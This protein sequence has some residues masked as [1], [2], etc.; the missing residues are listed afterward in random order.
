MILGGQVLSSALLSSALATMATHICFNHSNP[1]V[2]AQ[3]AMEWSS[4]VKV[5]P[6]PGSPTYSKGVSSIGMEIEGQGSLSKDYTMDAC[7]VS[8]NLPSYDKELPPIPDSSSENSDDLESTGLGFPH[9]AVGA[10]YTSGI[11]QPK[12]SVYSNAPSS[13][14]DKVPAPRCVEEV[15]LPSLNRRVSTPSESAEKN[16]EITDEPY[17]D[18]QPC[19]AKSVS[20]S[21]SLLG[22]QPS[23]YDVVPPPRPKDEADKRKYGHYD[24][25]PSPASESDEYIPCEILTSVSPKE[26]LP[27]VPAQTYNGFDRLPSDE[28]VGEN[29]IYDV[30]PGG[31]SDHTALVSNLHITD[32]NSNSS[33]AMQS[34]S[35]SSDEPFWEGTNSQRLQYDGYHSS[36][37]KP[38]GAHVEDPVIYDDPSLSHENQVDDLYDTPPP[39][40]GNGRKEFHDT[41]LGPL[42]DSPQGLYDTPPVPSRN[43]GEGSDDASSQP[44]RHTMD[45]IYDTP[46]VPSRNHGEG[47]DDASSQPCRHTMDEIYDTPPVPSRNCTEEFE[48]TSSGPH[49]QNLQEIYDTPPVPRRNDTKE[50]DDTQTDRHRQNQQEIYDTPPIPRRNDTKEFYDTST[51]RHRQNQ[52]EIYDTPPIPRRNDTQ[53]FDGNLSDPYRYNLQDIYDTPP[54]PNRNDREGFS[55]TQPNAYHHNHQDI[56]DSPPAP[57][58]NDRQ[59]VHDDPSDPYRFEQ[60]DIYDT[61]PAPKQSGSQNLYDFPPTLRNSGT[62]ETPDFPQFQNRRPDLTFEPG[63]DSLYDI[64]PKYELCNPR[65]QT[66]YDFSP[67][68]QRFARQDDIYDVPPMAQSQTM[69]QPYGK[70]PLPCLLDGTGLPVFVLVAMLAT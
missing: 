61:P 1:F 6:T 13:L 15:I 65:S 58:R 54:A 34:D 42:Q 23:A 38:V 57:N 7:G 62:Q 28:T 24:V 17:V 40:R 51:D 16:N 49:R 25:V 48:D 50:F 68:S 11:K 27:P 14:Y 35:G 30:P 26:Y 52:Q 9:T 29:S 64:P 46:P 41:S 56:S 59:N 47:S 10:P 21:N 4:K 31:L 53:E 5:K 18:M 70:Q 45:E 69:M 8:D 67:K 37:G 32:S 3:G 66:L 2:A 60:Q 36:Y 44:C 33:S 22:N 55:D 63:A 19:D 43:H 12:S 39:P 20:R